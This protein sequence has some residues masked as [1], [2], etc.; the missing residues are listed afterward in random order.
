MCTFTMFK[1]KIL[2]FHVLRGK[3]VNAVSSVEQKGMG[4]GMG[5]VL[6]ADLSESCV[7]C[8]SE[9]RIQTLTVVQ[10]KW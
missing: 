6:G 9:R 4:M 8:A 10:L 7:C 1:K 2:R 5:T 3:G